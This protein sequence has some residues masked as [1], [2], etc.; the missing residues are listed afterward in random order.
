MVD[1]VSFG[2]FI[3]AAIVMGTEVDIH[4]AILEFLPGQGKR[5]AAAVAKQQSTK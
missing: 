2:T 5:M 4:L 3:R 1:D